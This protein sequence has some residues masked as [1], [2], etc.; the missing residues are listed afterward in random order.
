M[1]VE[2]IDALAGACLEHSEATELN[3]KAE[4]M[5]R[6]HYVIL[7]QNVVGGRVIEKTDTTIPSHK[8]SLGFVHRLKA[9]LRVQTT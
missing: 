6:W 9:I 3:G 5:P 7:R 4:L 2:I 8:R 1:W